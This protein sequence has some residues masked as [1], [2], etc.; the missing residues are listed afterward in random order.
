MGDIRAFGY[1]LSILKDVYMA[2]DTVQ[3][4]FAE[5]FKTLRNLGNPAAFAT[6]L[7]LNAKRIALDL[8]DKLLSRC[9][10]G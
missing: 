7:R 6:W 5:V 9:K 3:E 8:L 4:S 1:A 2:E 10:S